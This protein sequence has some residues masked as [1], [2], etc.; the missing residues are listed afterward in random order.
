MTAAGLIGAAAVAHGLLLAA[1]PSLSRPDVYFSVTV[2]DGFRTGLA[3]RDVLLRYR[4]IVAIVTFAAL[5]A[6]SGTSSARV[7]VIA[8]ASQSAA[9]MAAW[10]WARGRMRPHASPEPS[11][12]MASL[13]PRDQSLPGGPAAAAGPFLILAA[14][15]AILYANW[16]HIPERF[17]T[18]WNASGAP[19][20]WTLKSPGS[21]FG[22]VLMGLAIL[23]LTLVQTLLVL[24]RTR[25]IAAAGGAAAAEQLF[26]RRNALYGVFAM[27]MMALMFS[28]FSTRN[29]FTEDQALG[30]GIWVLLGIVVTG[31]VLMTLWMVRVGQ[32][33]QRGFRATRP[34]GDATPDHAWKAGLVYFNPADPAVFVE[35]RMG[36]GWTLNLG[37]K[38]SWV[39]VA[40]LFVPLAVVWLTR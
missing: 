38:W 36:F 35:R 15:A 5:A 25:Q 12:R 14:A 6:L 8:L 27:Y 20:R 3:A 7:G 30:S 32:G 23:T 1:M 31:A 21:V 26:K 13:A 24:R 22:P 39:F 17:P 40:A 11:S 4:C 10:A 37:N 19:D 18:H 9:A 34:V 28:Y 16:D 29:L 33:G 2:P